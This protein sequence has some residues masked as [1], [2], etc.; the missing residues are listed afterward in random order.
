MR[1]ILILLI[2]AYRRF[3]RPI[4]PPR[5]CLFQESCSSF[6]EATLKNYGTLGGI[7]AMRTRLKQCRAGYKPIRID[8]EPTF[9]QMADGSQVAVSEL[10]TAMQSY[11][12]E[13]ENSATEESRSCQV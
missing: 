2:R 10:S 5:E 4:L 11:C 12:L 8:S 3:L 9:C 1:T 13:A 7:R 6:V